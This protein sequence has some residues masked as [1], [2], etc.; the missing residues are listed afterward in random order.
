[1]LFHG[2]SINQIFSDQW[3]VVQFSFVL[4]LNKTSD[5]C[6]RSIQNKHA[7][8]SRPQNPVNVTKSFWFLLSV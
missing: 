5:H 6:V 1:M 3:M 8:K 2:F 4:I 7:L